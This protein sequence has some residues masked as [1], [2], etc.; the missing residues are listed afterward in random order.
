MSTNT[1]AVKSFAVLPK[2]INTTKLENTDSVNLS[3]LINPCLI[4]N[5]TGN[6]ATEFNSKRYTMTTKNR[7]VTQR[8]FSSVL[9]W[10]ESPDM[11]DLFYY[12]QD[13]NLEF[14]YDYKELQAMTANTKQ[15]EYVLSARPTIV[16]NN[17]GRSE[18]IALCINMTEN[19]CYLTWS[20][21][22]ILADIVLNFDFDLEGILLMNSFKLGCQLK[23]VV[24]TEQERI[25][26]KLEYGSKDPFGRNH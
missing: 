24:T 5:Y 18:G 22:E 16:E 13:G 20:E 8:F 25:N 14:N 12:T 15:N 7:R 19:Q 6:S 1:L 11:Q 4:I 2:L 23:R 3:V 9:E 21:F 17:L 26:K 10:F